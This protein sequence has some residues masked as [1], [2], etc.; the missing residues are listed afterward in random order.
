MTD[1]MWLPIKDITV[2]PSKLSSSSNSTK[3]QIELIVELCDS[4]KDDTLTNDNNLVKNDTD[5]VKK[6]KQQL[7]STLKKQWSINE[8]KK[9]IKGVKSSKDNK[10]LFLKVTT[11]KMR[12]SIK[13]KDE[14]ENSAGQIYVKTTVFEHGILS[15]SWKC[16]NFLP[17]LSTRWDSDISTIIVPIGNEENLK[18]ISIRTTVAT[19]TK[20]W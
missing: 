8:M 6:E 12:C 2:T 4:L 10:Q 15:N 5:G 1:E 16:D 3:G 17:S 13:V 11:S 20:S 18:N 19:K 9:K 7:P 14:F